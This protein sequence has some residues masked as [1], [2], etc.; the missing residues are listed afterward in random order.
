MITPEELAAKLRST[1]EAKPIFDK[2]AQLHLWDAAYVLVSSE[3]RLDNIEFETG[4]R[5]GSQ[6]IV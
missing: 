2:M 3:Y 1:P 6:R 4:L 5:N